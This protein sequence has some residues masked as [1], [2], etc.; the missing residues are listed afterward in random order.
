MR[1]TVLSCIRALLI[2]LAIAHAHALVAT[3][4]LAQG[5][6]TVAIA[7]A[8]VDADPAFAPLA[9]GYALWLRNG[10]ANIGAQPIWRG[11]GV[12]A[13][14]VLSDAAEWG[15]SHVLVPRLRDHDDGVEA[16]LLLYAAASRELVAATRSAGPAGDPGPAIAESFEDLTRQLGASS[17]TPATAPLID[18]LASSS[19]ALELHESGQLYEA[20]RAVNGKISPTAISLRDAIAA[21]ARAGEGSPTERA[22]V[23]AA[24][25]D[26]GTAW[27][28][29]GADAQAALTAPQADPA[30]LVAAGEVQL[31]RNKPR[32]A[33][34][35]F[36]RAASQP[37]PGAISA[38]SQLGLARVLTLQRDTDGARAALESAARLA[39]ADPQPHEMLARLDRTH[40]DRAAQHLMAA[41]QRS[42]Q[43]L[44]PSRARHQ[45]G[46]AVELDPR[47][48]ADSQATVAHLEA[49]QGR[50]A[51]TLDAYQAALA[52][53]ADRPELHVDAGHAHRSMGND[54]AAERAFLRA[55]ALDENYGPALSELGALYTDTG[56][57]DEAVALLQT[58]HSANAGDGKV[59]RRYARALEA[60]GDRKRAAAV[61]VPNPKTAPPVELQLAAS[62]RLA[63]GD[64]NGA[65]ALLNR[66]NQLDPGDADLRESLARV[67]E[68][69]GDTAG[70]RTHR[71]V[72]G[73]LTGSELTATTNELLKTTF[74]T[75]RSSVTLDQYVMTFASQVASP[76]TRH[77]SPIGVRQLWRWSA[78]SDRL[79]QLRTV[80]V[81][82]IDAA[83]ESA[84]TTHFG[85]GS[86]A[87]GE[88]DVLSS[89]IDQ[90]YDFE[91]DASLDAAAIATVN[92]VLGVDGVFLS[93]LTVVPEEA[94]GAACEAGALQLE[95]RLLMGRH[96]DV[97]S[98]LA[99]TDCLESGVEAYGRW[100]YEAF[101]VYAAILLF[102]ALPMFRGWGS[103]HVTIRLPE[104]TKG[105]L[106]IHIATKPDQVRRERVDKKT[107][108][109][110]IRA[111]R[112]F[113]FLKRFERNMA[114]RETNFRW[115]PARK[116][117]YTVTVGGPLI[118]AQGDEI[119]GH[120]LEER[121]VR[122]HRGRVSKLEF[123][124]R[125]K[126]CAIELHIEN[127]RAPAAGGRAAVWGDRDSLRYARDGVAYLYLGLG[128]Y[129]IAVGTHDSAAAIPLDVKSLDNAIP[130]QVDFADDYNVVFR[131]CPEAVDPYLQRDL[132]SAARALEASGDTRAANHMRGMLFE[133]QGRS[134]DAAR[135]FEAAGLIENAAKVRATDSDFEGSAALFEQA[136]D[137]E[138]A[139]DAYRA[140]GQF[141]EA[142]RC[143]ENV[144]DYHNALEC[145]R[146]VGN[147]EREL[148]LLEKIGEYVAAG[149][150]AREQADYDRAISNLQQI[151]QRH[152]NYGDA[153]RMIGEMLIE[154]EDF[155]LAVAK[156]EEA[157]GSVG[158]ENASV[159]TLEG[160]A[161]ALEG[162]GRTRDAIGALEAICRRD[163][164]RDDVAERI[165]QLKKS[166]GGSETPTVAAAAPATARAENR[167][168]LIEEIGRGGMG[169]VY[170]ARDSR[171]GRIVALKRLPEN[172]REHPRAVELFEREARA[173]A[174]LN[175]VNIVTLFDAG[176]EDGSFFITMELLEGRALNEILERNGRLSARDV[177]RIGIQIAK[178]M[179]Y[180]HEQRIVHRDIKT[181]NLF[182]T[183]D[184]V[185]KIM[186]FGIAKSL[187]EVRRS[188]TVVGGTP[189]YMAPE[190]ASGQPV[191]HRA[192]LYAFG[193]T[194][195][196]LAAGTLPFPDGDVTYRHCHEP[197]PNPREV[198]MTIPEPLAQLILALMA[199]QPEERPASAAAVGNALR[200]LLTAQSS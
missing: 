49:R 80:D 6:D 200:T 35:Y 86:P 158:S 144:Y 135:E 138:Q 150:L 42:A 4:A 121:Q 184:Q 39:P 68:N 10:L 118:E 192:D 29:I 132:A 103:L 23:L 147:T 189:F 91:G 83:L 100:N 21:Q 74:S 12:D 169:V 98:I 94:E 77:I 174:A 40:P 90:L 111:T 167:Y 124:F 172:L 47:H 60:V 69:E 71:D 154:R 125:P 97:A 114:S 164:R 61:L 196:Q 57:S 175:H 149:E 73:Q 142:A 1:T 46:R 199:K 168:E 15:A 133:Q 191:D 24:T 9:A 18:E 52:A 53:G 92:Q 41:A 50:S 66:A 145:W 51:E 120:F 146:E 5:S 20:W 194:L 123:D 148:D 143:Y 99:N 180:A 8:P 155:D 160:F 17:A 109:E 134:E 96:A 130:L 119:I 122:V 128:S 127:E 129:T 3:P 48:T 81:A 161:T 112:R 185:V 76:E 27:R 67:L 22:R 44:D 197:A 193:V 25:K 45:L 101:A 166:I 195:F 13:D 153:C 36:E 173:A 157:I 32:E 176:E 126:E 165:E 182:F 7:V 152:V 151:D 65:K 183:K 16:Q 88:S 117:E 84:L 177:A 137:A 78:L 116:G 140:A 33:R 102:L 85:R 131:G 113:D 72:A 38:S 181:A 79:T 156:F 14:A 179:H 163:A 106:S 141:D 19:R 159:E 11:A 93:R 105:F 87:S 115:I 54:G 75:Q 139:A 136:G 59:R 107:N 43:R 110:K 82:V 186:D 56:R 95:S 108:R 162:A 37:A 34:R 28:L 2:G 171:L 70:A 188:T 62:M 58:A 170:K 198:D 178:G 30:L 89:R 64:P 187:E 63:L 26:T 55:L 31:A 104:R 190:Q